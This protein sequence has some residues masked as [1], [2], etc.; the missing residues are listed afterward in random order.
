MNEGVVGIFSET[1]QVRWGQ[2]GADHQKLIS[3]G[4]SSQ[5]SVETVKFIIKFW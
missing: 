2:F 3:Y 1:V 4:Q 5:W